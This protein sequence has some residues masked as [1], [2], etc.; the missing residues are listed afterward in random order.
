MIKIVIADENASSLSCERKYDASA[1]A[2]PAFV[3]EVRINSSDPG[4]TASSF[5]RPDSGY[6]YII[7]PHS[8][9]K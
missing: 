9:K 8:E 4:A 3:Q 7:D 5:N 1:K 6:V 2:L